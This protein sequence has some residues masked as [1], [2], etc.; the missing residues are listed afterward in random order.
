[1]PNRLFENS[2]TKD[3]AGPNTPYM[4]WHYISQDCF[5]VP[6]QL[7]DNADNLVGIPGIIVQGRYDLLCPPKSAVQLAARWPDA[8]L[9]IIP[10]SGHS[11]AE[12]LIRSALVAAIRD[13]KKRVKQP[14]LSQ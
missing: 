1:M 11:A 4:E 2:A 3:N 12:P 8:E 5:L 10:G 14:T 7:L 6:G 9:R 13:I